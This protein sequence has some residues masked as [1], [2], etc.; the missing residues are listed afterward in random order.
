MRG[1]SLARGRRPCG[2]SRSAWTWARPPTPLGSLWNHSDLCAER[3]PVWPRGWW[4]C[5]PR[6]LDE[7]LQVALAQLPVQ[8][9]KF[10]GLGL[11]HMGPSGDAATGLHGLALSLA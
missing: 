10:L 1:S 8:L 2:E 11:G 7:L 4:Q 9:L 5:S 6:L 3:A